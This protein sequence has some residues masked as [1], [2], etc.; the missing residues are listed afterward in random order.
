[1]IK[2]TIDDRYIKESLRIRDSYLKSLT[3]LKN[4]EELISSI[5]NDLN[6]S[7]KLVNETDNEIDKEFVENKINELTINI[8]NL[9]K[10]LKPSIENI[11]QLTKDAN[12]LYDNI[13]EKYPDIKKE[14]LQNI[15]IPYMKEIDDKYDI[16]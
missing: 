3:E 9:Q 13:K 1:M 16:F 4:N 14:E 7:Y 8:K 6:N 2:K 12:V 15:L 10:N 11:E 5:K